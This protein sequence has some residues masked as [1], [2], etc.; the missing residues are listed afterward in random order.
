M[1]Q[2]QL[3]PQPKIR[4]DEKLL[5]FGASSLGLKLNK[6]FNSERYLF[7]EAIV[8]SCSGQF[9]HQFHKS[10]RLTESME[11]CIPIVTFHS[12]CSSLFTCRSY[13]RLRYNWLFSTILQNTNYWDCLCSDYW[14]KNINVLVS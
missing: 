8:W 7:S 1:C 10:L 11:Y 4:F 2:L 6:V 3:L 14:F 5:C 13:C 9:V 12:T